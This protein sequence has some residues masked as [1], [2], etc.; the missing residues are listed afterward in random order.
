MAIASQTAYPDSSTELSKFLQS[1]QAAAE[2]HTVSDQ[3]V[4]DQQHL[5]F[6]LLRDSLT[7]AQYAWAFGN[8]D[9]VW[10][11]QLLD[12]VP[13]H[14][15][16]ELYN[17]QRE[18]PPYGMFESGPILVENSGSTSAKRRLPFSLHRWLKYVTPASR[19]LTYYGV[20]SS[21]LILTT[22]PGGTQAGYRTIEEAGSWLC[23]STVIPERSS[24]L[25]RKLETIRD[26]GI[27]VFVTNGQKI[28]R[29]LKQ[30]VSKYLQHTMKLVVIT[31]TPTDRIR[32]IEDRFQCPVTEYYGSSEMGHTYYTCNQGRRHLH[33]DF[34]YPG[35][36]KGKTVFNNV[37]TL[38]IFN[39]NLGDEIDYEWNGQCDCG[40][41]L[42]VVTHFKTK[43]FSQI[44]KE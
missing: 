34:V 15:P 23:G 31:G 35:Q 16:E 39:Y 44:I 37:A 10:I 26:Y 32:A 8:N 1:L 38:P 19:G 42:P 5:N 14:T 9:P 4:C 18:H 11:D 13:A 12:H 20:D 29:L 27:T 3:A 6:C 7:E 40:S 25:T 22:D 24:S 2:M 43:N 41:Y 30:N 28:E 33:V 36:K 17:L 21:D